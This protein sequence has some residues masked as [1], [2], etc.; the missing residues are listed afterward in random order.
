M[1]YKPFQDLQLSALGMG[2][3]RL[4]TGEDGV[5]DERKAREI[6]TYAYENGVNYFDTAYRYHGGQSESFVGK[7]LKDFPRDSWYI[8]SKMPG[9]MMSY[10]NGKL[11][12]V[13][14]LAGEKVKSIAQIFEE[15]LEKCGVEYFDFY[16][17]HNVC[18]TSYDFYTNEE[19][20]V[21]RYLLEQKKNGKIRHLGFSTHG[22]T[23][24]IRR[25]LDVYPGVF[26]F[27]QIQ[28]NYID[29]DLQEAGEKY[30]LLTGR[31]IPVIAM[32]PVRGGKLCELP[33]GVR[34][35]LEKARPGETDASWAFR[36]LQSLDNMQVVLSG[37][38]TLE[39]LKEN[40]ELFSNPKPVTEEERKLLRQAAEKMVDSVPCTK[41]R[42]CCEEC[43]QGL[44]I[45][46]L[47]SLYEQANFSGMGLLNFNIGR[48]QEQELPG[49]CIGCGA[50]SAVCPQ[51]IEIPGLL[52]KLDAMMV[53]AKK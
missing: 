48:M 19:L 6:I 4:P 23:D 17:L 22:M 50:C 51:N 52:G 32:E 53:G 24:T 41:C 29:W 27:A 14:Y 3:M 5:I 10:E 2:N 15:Q 35:P 46:L 12:F 43:P 36:F 28:I 18:E 45:P 21:V 31:G 11:G 42:Y 47:L 49:A 25:F 20:G 40:I 26:E 7:V 16:L 38:S 9:H 39:Q 33:E 30:R 44:D 34:E 37:M 13:G 8:A 1:Q